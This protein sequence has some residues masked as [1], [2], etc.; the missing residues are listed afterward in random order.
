[1]VPPEIVKHLYL[2][3]LPQDQIKLIFEL[4]AVMELE[5]FVQA[6]YTLEGDGT[7][8]F[9]AFEEREELKA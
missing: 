3:A 7:L 8:V 5:K 6:A 4:A 2:F 9:V 1:M